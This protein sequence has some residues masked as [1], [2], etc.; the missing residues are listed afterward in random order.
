MSTPEFLAE[1]QVRIVPNTAGFRQALVA[2]LTKEVALAEKELA[3]ATRTATT[4]AAQQATVQKRAAAAAT[5]ETAALRAQAKAA[6]QAARAHEQLT[7]GAGSAG[8]ALL[9]ARGATLAAGS[10]FLIGAAAVTLLS[11][12]VQGASEEAEIFFTLQRIEGPQA[13]AETKKWASALAE[14][15]GLADEQAVKFVTALEA[16][17]QN[18]GLAGA[19]FQGFSKELTEAAADLAALRHIPVETTLKA[20]QLAIAGNSRGLKQLS[21]IQTATRVN[22]EALIESGKKEVAQ[23]TEQDRVLARTNLILHDAAIASGAFAA[24][25]GELANRTAI[26]KANLNELGDTVGAI[27]IPP[28]Q[29]VASELNETVKGIKALIDFAKQSVPAVGDAGDHQGFWGD[30]LD[31]FNKA[32][33][34]SLFILPELFRQFGLIGGA[35]DKAASATRADVVAFN[36]LRGPIDLIMNLAGG[37]SGGFDRAAAAFRR[38]AAVDLSRAINQLE[39]ANQKVLQIQTSGG[40]LSEILSAQALPVSAAQ[41]EVEAAFAVPLTGTPTQKKKIIAARTAALNDLKS[42]QEAEK[43]TRDQIASDAGAAA[44]KAEQAANEAAAAAQKRL[45]DQD[46]QLAFEQQLAD[47]RIRIKQ[48][49]ADRTKSLVD[50]IARDR[51]EIALIKQQIID[52][53]RIN[54]EE[55]RKL[56]LQQKRGELIAAQDQ[57]KQDQAEQRQRIRDRKVTAAEAAV[58]SAQLDAELAETLKRPNAQIA[59]LQRQNV[60]LEKEKALWQGNTLK[61]KEIRNQIAANN[62]AIKDL[63]KQTDQ[64]RDDL[65]ALQFSFLQTQSGFAANLLSNLIPTGAAVGTVGGGVGTATASVGGGGISTPTPLS[66]DVV[67]TKAAGTPS[68]GVTQGQMAVQ[69]QI[70]RGILLAVQR[71]NGRHTHPG[72]ATE[73]VSQ[74]T[75]LDTYPH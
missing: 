58:T 44:A 64:R 73:A 35:A 17:F 41:K 49:K 3:G 48:A 40:S 12:A 14:G 53:H 20:I 62:Q 75:R 22:Q 28:L 70:L 1:A 16:T 29:K 13:A 42:A 38:F 5:Q 71:L 36:E 34:R 18:V 55:Q 6:A 37:L 74:A 24:R 43:S 4:A 63:K 56:T 11:K 66:T 30:R 47:G 33:N 65:L 54:D 25:S 23:L 45:D 10:Q 9:G 68:P 26:L 50:D 32:A 67:N 19:K 57:L 59:A 60:A 39:L 2:Q 51:E 52:A 7:R 31:D 46:H 8:L 27:L 72:S 61:L 69:I 15:F 21:I